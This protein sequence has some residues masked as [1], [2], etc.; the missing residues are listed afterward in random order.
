MHFI[1]GNR[2]L[3][4]LSEEYRDASGNLEFQQK[5]ECFDK[6]DAAPVVIHLP[7][8]LVPVQSR[9]VQALVSVFDS[10]GELLERFKAFDV[11]FPKP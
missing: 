9:K 11:R 1:K 7:A 10:R 5:A 8:T 6:D 2:E 4:A 3:P